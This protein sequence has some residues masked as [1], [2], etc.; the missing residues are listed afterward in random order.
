MQASSSPGF[1]GKVASHGDFVSRRLPASFVEGWDNWLQHGL[2]AS[3]EKLGQVWLEIYLTSPI[4]RFALSAEVLDSHAWAGIIM[5]SVDRVGR[6]FPLTIAA[7]IEGQAAM[8]ECLAREKSWYDDLETLALSSLENNFLM[9]DFD[10]A[11]QRMSGFSVQ[12]G[13]SLVKSRTQS[14]WC[15]P[16]DDLENVE[17]GASLITNKIAETL[18]SVHS[19]WWTEGSPHVHPSLL[20]CR[21]L[22]EPAQFTAMLDGSWSQSG[23]QLP[24]L[25]P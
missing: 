15:F 10:V 24:E 18:L 3:R 12:S 5:P 22:P 19:M 25:V 16:I 1:F 23:W 7:K 2:L 11:L 8:L 14:A 13:K 4:W 21:G 9:D 20:V 17:A 6:H